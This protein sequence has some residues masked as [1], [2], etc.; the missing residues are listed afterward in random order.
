M[1]QRFPHG[2]SFAKLFLVIGRGG[3]KSLI[4]ALLVLCL[5]V[6]AIVERLTVRLAPGEK[7]TVMSI[8]AELRQTRVVLGYIKG[9]IA[10][11]PLLKSRVVRETQ[12]SI[13]FRDG[14]VIE[15][16]TASFRS[17]RGY[18]LLGVVCDELAYFRSEENAANRD[19]EIINAIR[20]GLAR[21]PGSLLI[22][23][24]SPW[25]GKVRCGRRT[26]STSARKA[27]VSWCGK[28]TR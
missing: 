13:E 11:V 15:S 23:I 20:P 5:V 27:N 16:H 24:S 8:S 2:R 7:L 21:V 9:F 25:G 22:C 3:G 14:I 10:V 26:T 12:N 18:S 28:R 1:R 19:E 6:R 4:S 17:T